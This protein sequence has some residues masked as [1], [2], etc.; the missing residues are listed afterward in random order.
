[1]SG[2]DTFSEP[3]DVCTLLSKLIA[4]P[5]PNPRGDTQAIAH[6]VSQYLTSSETKIQIVAP[7]AKPEAQSVIATVG[8]GDPVILL[9]AHIDTVPIAEEEKTLWKTDPYSADIRDGCLFGK[10]AVD[11]KACVAFMMNGFKECA[12][13][14]SQHRGTLILVAAAEEEVGGQL[15]THY[16]VEEGFLSEADF[17]IVGEQTHNRIALAHK[18]VMRARIQTKGKSV[19]ATDPDRGVNAITAM[20][21][22]ILAL[23]EYHSELSQIKHDLVGN[24]TCNIGTIRGGSTTNAVPDTCEITIDRR[25]I[26]REDP[27]VVVDEI[28]SIISN[29]EIS[30][31]TVSVDT[32]LFSSWFESELTTTLASIMLSAMKLN[33]V[34]EL[35]PT[36]YLPGSDAKHLMPVAR[37]D[38]VIFGPGSYK[39]AHS[40]NEFVAINELVQAESV[41]NT[42]LHSAFKDHRDNRSAH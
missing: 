9:H 41:L 30:P 39:A 6:F 38:I 17:V 10:G 29:L 11:D 1:M 27:N 24:P 40:A 12:S 5:S 26:P 36:G 23:T 19:H 7:E 25:M 22:V 2:L 4:I 20:S 13:R 35:E 15:G 8:S 16:L 37:G 28:K 21:S 32:F 34:K 33:D 31:A 14:F 18:G 42:F 3:L